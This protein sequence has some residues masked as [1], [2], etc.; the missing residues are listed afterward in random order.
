MNPLIATENLYVGFDSRS[1]DPVQRGRIY[2]NGNHF[3]NFYSLDESWGGTDKNGWIAFNRDS[4]AFDMGIPV[5]EAIPSLEELLNT[6]ETHLV[7]L[8]YRK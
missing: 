1:T 5:I 8:N 6:L 2:L 4:L 3:A 7:R